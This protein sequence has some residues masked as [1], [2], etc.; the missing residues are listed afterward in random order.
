MTKSDLSISEWKVVFTER[1]VDYVSPEKMFGLL[2]SS[3]DRMLTELDRRF[4]YQGQT[5]RVTRHEYAPVT[6][7]CSRQ[8]IFF[9][10]DFVPALKFDFR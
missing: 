4:D 7:V 9:E 1:G 10:V 8:G 3:I 6:M 2:M 5:Y